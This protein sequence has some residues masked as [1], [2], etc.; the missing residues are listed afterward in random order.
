MQLLRL[1]GKL[2]I[3]VNNFTQWELIANVHSD[4]PWDNAVWMQLHLDSSST[5][6]VTETLVNDDWVAKTYL[7]RQNSDLLWELVG[8]IVLV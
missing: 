2:D 6:R 7:S 3:W 8:E 1:L 4:L 5:V